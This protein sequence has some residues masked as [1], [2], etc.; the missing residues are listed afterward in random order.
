MREI[1]KEILDR[2]EFRAV[3]KCDP[4]KKVVRI[5]PI[6]PCEACGRELEEVRRITIQPRCEPVRHRREYC[7]NCRLVAVS[8]T[9]EFMPCH[10][11]NRIMRRWKI[12]EDK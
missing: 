6:A 12:Q 10:E 5:K 11:L 7:F 4:I 2:L 8:G 3:A 9:N 1:P